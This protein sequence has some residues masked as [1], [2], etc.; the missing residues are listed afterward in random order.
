MLKDG[1]WQTE[2]KCHPV[3]YVTV[4]LCHCV[5]VS[6]C[7]C[8]T[9]S[10]CHCEFIFHEIGLFLQLFFRKEIL[11]FDKGGYNNHFKH[12]TDHQ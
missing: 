3:G 7:H 4:S 1:I 11:D 2:I 5:T 12:S 10:L 8:V 9:V 6:L